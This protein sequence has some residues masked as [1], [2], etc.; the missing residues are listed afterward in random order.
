MHGHTNIKN[1]IIKMYITY[2]P[3]FL[4]KSSTFIREAYIRYKVLC[5]EAE[6]EKLN[7]F[8]QRLA[9]SRPLE[10]FVGLFWWSSSRCDS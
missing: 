4:K 7:T 3:I 5:M 8:W 9:P 2:F 6:E 1:K 10:H